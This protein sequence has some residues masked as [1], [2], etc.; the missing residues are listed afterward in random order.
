MK[1]DP[2]FLNLSKDFWAHVRLI[3][4][5]LR[6]SDRATH[7][8]KVPSF[9]DQVGSLDVLGMSGRRIAD[10]S[11]KPTHFGKQL[12]NY[13]DYRANVL[14][15]TVEPCLMDAPA[16][17]DLFNKVRRR[18]R[19]QMPVPMNK[20][21][22]KKKQPAYLT[23]MV[24]MI[25]HDRCKEQGCDFDPRVLIRITR[26][27]LP[28]C[29]LARRVDGAFPSTLNPVAVWEVKE[30]YYTTTFGSRVADG[31]YETLLDGMELEDL[32]INERIDVKHYLMLDSHYTWWE[33]GRSYLC[34]VIDMLHMAYV[35][36]VLFGKEIVDRLP[37]IVDEW[38]QI[39]RD[40]E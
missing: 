28:L 11:C 35:D 14:N 1:P 21:K 13:F 34:R 38:L 26:D 29:A 15:N 19:S 8:I 9:E 37:A 3:S 4:E 5:H 7:Q 23:G 25:I 16:A 31:I 22:G 33:C 18:L 30:Y 36:E 27:G 12:S 6:Y 40:R 17:K 24:N 20:Q 2:R 32:R 10:D 39:L